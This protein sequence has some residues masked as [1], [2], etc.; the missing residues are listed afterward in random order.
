VPDDLAAVDGGG[1][2]TPFRLNWMKWLDNPRRNA[3]YE[4]HCIYCNA[5]KINPDKSIKFHISDPGWE[6]DIEIIAP[7]WCSE[8]CHTLWLLTYE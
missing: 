7:I 5:Q 3:V 6:N 4:G 8:E 2:M 1:G